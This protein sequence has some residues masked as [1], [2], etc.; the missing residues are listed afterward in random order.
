MT[1][2]KSLAVVQVLGVFSLFVIYGGPEVYAQE[3]PGKG[4]SIRAGVGYGLNEANIEIGNGWVYS[5]GWQKDLGQENRLRVNPNLVFGLFS[6]SS[7]LYL[8][9]PNQFYRSLTI[10][11]NIH[12][13]LIKFKTFSFVT[14]GGAFISH[15]KGLIGP[16]LLT[17]RA[18][19][20]SRYFRFLYYGGN[21]SLGF[22]IDNDD[23]PF[24]YELIPF[25][26]HVGDKAF[27]LAYVMFAME[28]KLEGG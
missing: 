9:Y 6:P 21:L 11:L 15:S 25:N 18:S 3:R 26:M 1:K 17:R 27:I 16:G 4:S 19:G 10:R 24:A 14:T 12:Y 22:R 7:S 13:D 23:S 28:I 2:G 5:L 20:E 8:N